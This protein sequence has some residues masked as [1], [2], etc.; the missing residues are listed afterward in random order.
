[1]TPTAISQVSE[2]SLRVVVGLLLTYSLLDRGI[3]IAAGGASFGGSMGA[4]AGTVAIVII[5]L[6][7]KKE[8]NIEISESL[9]HEEE[10]TG[11]IIKD[12]LVIAIPITIGASIAP[13]MDTID[14]ALVMRRLQY[15]GFSEFEANDLYGQLKGLA[16]TLINLPQVFSMALAISLVPA[17]SDAY[18]RKK[19]KDMRN[20]ISSGVRM[21]LLIGLPSAFGLFVL[22]KPIIRLLYFKNTLES[23]NSTGEILQILAFGVIF[24]TLVQ[25]LTAILQGLGKPIIPVRNLFVG[26]V[27]KTVLTYTLTGLLSINVKG[28]A[29]ST[30]VAY[31]I[32]AT[33]DIISV[34]KH[35]KIKLNISEVFVRPFIS[36][37]G[38]AVIAKVCHVFLYSIVGDKLATIIAI[39]I[40]V[41]TYF[42]LLVRTGSLTY[43]DFK[44]LPKGEKI[45]NKLV[46][47][48]LLKI[49]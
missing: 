28:A 13:I 18:A 16:Q 20:I 23:L 11:K 7:K 44:I 12:L 32:A 33:L 38:M 42:M 10:S 43:E 27:V 26:A 41:I 39:F 22:A 31:L 47:L 29:I 14:T 1:M 49:N 45:A 35:T 15:I 46:K 19:Y 30:V 24:L 2:Q 4:I 36:A 5:Y 21:T 17:I 8:I 37:A 9:N 48:K 34:R 25:S 3:P 40:G 6:F